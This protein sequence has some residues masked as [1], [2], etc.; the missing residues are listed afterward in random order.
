LFY[1]GLPQLLIVSHSEHAISTLVLDNCLIN[2][3]LS[4]VEHNTRGTQKIAPVQYDFLRLHC[5]VLTA[6]RKR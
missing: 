6:A 3:A 4:I 1:T 5:A 2:L